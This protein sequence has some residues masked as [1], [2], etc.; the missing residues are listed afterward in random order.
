[1]LS[2]VLDLFRQ[3]RGILRPFNGGLGNGQGWGRGTI[4]PISNRTG[5]DLPLMTVVHPV[6]AGGARAEPTTTDAQTD[7]LGVVV[8][9]LDQTGLL[10]EADAPDGSTVA[11]LTAGVTSVLIDANVE[12]G[13]FAFAAATDGQARGG[14]SA[15]PGA[16]GQFVGSGAAG[17]YALVRLSP[18]GFG[19]SPVVYAPTT[20]DYLVG[21]A[22]AGLSA[23]IVVGATPGGELGNTWASPTVDTTHSGS[24]HAA[25][26]AA[27]ESYSDAA[28]AAHTGDTTDAHD[29]S[30]VSIADSGGYFAATDVEGA[31]QALASG[32]VTGAADPWTTII[33]AA[34]QDVF[35]NTT[36]V[37]DTHLQFATAAGTM[38]VIEIYII[39]ASPVGGGVPDIK[40]VVGEDGTPSRGMMQAN[41]FST[42]DNAQSSNLLANNGSLTAF[43]GAAAKRMILGRGAFLGNGGTMK[44]RWCQNTTSTDVTRVY[45]G[46]VLRYRAI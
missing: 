27:A 30:A 43:G 20:A 2:L 16:F 32:A 39:Y 22:Q 44:F 17:Q 13:D 5:G 11:V 41:G 4:I 1:M 38:Y 8:G 35:S 40:I 19:A 24:S 9:Y 31:L 7:V 46:S 37:D 3:V 34:D 15:G 42:A 18:T 10:I 29:A 21:T 33:K 36:G 6:T 14:A 23:E 25:T 45:A 26:E 12:R 28:L